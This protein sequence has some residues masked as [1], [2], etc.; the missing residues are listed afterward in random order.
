MLAQRADPR[1]TGVGG[2]PD[3]RERTKC[4][5]SEQI[6]A[7]TG[8]GGPPDRRQRTNCS[9][10]EHIAVQHERR[11]RNRQVSVPTHDWAMTSRVRAA[12][13]A[14]A[15]GA[16]IRLDGGREVRNARLG[17]GISQ[18][19]AG[20][21]V[22]MS[23]AQFGRIERAELGGLTIDQ[24]ARASR[25]VGLRLMVRSMPG[26]D[27]AIDA[28]QLALLNWLRRLLPVAIPMRTEVPLPFSGDRRAWDGIL[29]HPPDLVAVEAEARIRDVQAV[30]RRCALKQRDGRVERVILLVAATASNRAM[31]NLH[32]EALRTRFPLDGRAI[33]AD[34]RGGR[35]PGRSGILVL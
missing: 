8:V 32:R 5:P 19:A 1:C 11:W 18:A 13:E 30:E 29:G 28:G 25:A 17:L 6:R 21:R 26:D 3:Q 27:P 4:S 9:P 33:L 35:L 15:D 14:A 34:L 16:R 10:S 2:P 7:C 20:A 24:L 31:L 22:G 23:R 12:A